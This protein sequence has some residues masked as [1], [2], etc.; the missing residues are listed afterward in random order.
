MLSSKRKETL[1]QL[2]FLSCGS[3]IFLVFKIFLT[4]YLI[5]Y[6]FSISVSYLIVHLFL[7]ILSWLYHS[8]VTF[9]KKLSSSIFF[10]YSVATLLFKF[11]DYISVL[12]LIEIGNLTSTESI[13]ITSLYLFIFRYIFLKKKIFK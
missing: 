3:F 13:L 4:Y 1:N 5:N 8:L 7:L 2:F 6:H 11:V 12:F 9:K 10:D